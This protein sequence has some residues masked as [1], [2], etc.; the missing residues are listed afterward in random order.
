MVFQDLVPV[1]R[2]VSVGY[3]GDVYD[4]SPEELQSDQP[5]WVPIDKGWWRAQRTWLSICETEQE[6]VD[7][8]DREQQQTSDGQ[9]QLTAHQSRKQLLSPGPLQATGVVQ[10]RT[11]QDMLLH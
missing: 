11:T 6:E 1:H 8:K 7:G 5:T 2:D 9:V 10:K 3:Q 4:V